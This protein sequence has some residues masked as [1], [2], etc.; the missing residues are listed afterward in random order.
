M[1]KCVSI[2]S[3]AGGLD[4]G[5]INAGAQI[6]VCVENDPDAAQTLRLNN[7]GGHQSAVLEKTVE[8]VDFTHWRDDSETILIGGPP[9]QPFSKNGYWVKNDNRLIAG[10]PRNMLGQYLRAVSELQPT[11]F[12]F[13]N[14]ESIRHPTNIAVFERFLHD[15]E[16]MGYACTV[17]RAN[18]ADF[19]VPQKRK[20]V[21]VF[22]IRGAKNPI[23]HPHKTHSDPGKPEL[24]NGFAP[25]VGV[26]SFIK[27]YSGQ[28]Y[29]EPQ[30]DASNGTYYHELI[31][32]PAGKN[33]IA[34][35][36]LDNYSGRTFRAG[37]RFWNF[38]QKLHPEEPAITIAA[39]PGPWVGPFHWDNRRL[40]VPEVA[41]IQTFP[42]DY[43][44]AGNRRSIQKQIG[45][46]VPCLLGEVMVRHLL[47][48]L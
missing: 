16:A 33:Y 11:G 22:G 10:D 13:E 5:A 30:E 35:S 1:V 36:G 14:V 19:G 3:G 27:K 37:G 15:A 40:R 29:A 39:Q 12:L 24:M 18:S 17:Y 6:V 46:A 31:H 47:G 8:T 7:I 28:R 32:V 26:E 42:D 43:K 34:L 21:F 2:F 44:F 20:R 48:K 9:C 45:N 38:L 23:P 4:I 41:A 25:H